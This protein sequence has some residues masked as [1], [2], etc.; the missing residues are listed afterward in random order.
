MRAS[1][2]S[3][4]T[5]PRQVSRSCFLLISACREIVRG[6]KI[7]RFL[8]IPIGSPLSVSATHLV[9]RVH[10]N[11]CE[12]LVTWHYGSHGQGGPAFQQ[13]KVYPCRM[14]S[15]YDPELSSLVDLH[16]GC[17]VG[18]QTFQNGWGLRRGHRI[19][20]I[21]KI[22]IEKTKAYLRELTAPDAPLCLGVA[23]EAIAGSTIAQHKTRSLEIASILG[24]HV[25]T[26]DSALYIVTKTHEL[27]YAI[28]YPYLEYPFD[29]GPTVQAVK[30]Q[31]IS[32]CSSCIRQIPNNPAFRDQK[33]YFTDPLMLCL[34]GCAGQSGISWN[35]VSNIL[36]NC[37]ARV[38]NWI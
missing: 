12:A 22:D 16:E 37:W 18:N 26:R 11:G 30:T 31:T 24:N 29:T 28:R 2:S 3:F 5:G 14:V 8:T 7:N 21:S 9:S 10:L 17:L 27:A 19:A 1:R 36:H 25:D 34:I 13:V 38:S 32:R 15:F 20:G 6:K 35:G 23:W 33:S 4:A